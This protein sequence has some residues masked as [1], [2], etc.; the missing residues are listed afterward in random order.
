LLLTGRLFSHFVVDSDTILIADR[1]QL[2]QFENSGTGA[3]WGT[4]CVAQ[5]RAERRAVVDEETD[6]KKT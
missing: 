1:M 6:A 4:Y 2:S 3:G 5:G